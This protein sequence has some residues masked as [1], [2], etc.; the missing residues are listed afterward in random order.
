MKKL[1]LI[2][3]SSILMLCACTKTDI[4]IQGFVKNIRG[5]PIQDA[6][7][8][9]QKSKKTFETTTDP[10]GLYMFE[11]VPIGT[12]ELTVSKEG[13][14]TQT[15]IFSVRGGSSGNI[16]HKDFKLETPKP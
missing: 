9:I 16:Y 14:E 3:I 1:F 13:Y 11:N 15:E 7:V 5:V 6:T 10:T 12:W 4:R 2:F 8:T